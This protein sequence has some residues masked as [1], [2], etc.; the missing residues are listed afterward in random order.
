MHKNESAEPMTLKDKLEVVRGLLQNDNTGLWDVLTCQRGPDTP[1]ERSE[2]TASE[3]SA[4]YKARRER[5]Y[6]TVEVIRAAAGISASGARKH[7]DDKVVLPNSQKWDH[8]DRHVYAAARALGL[9]VE[10]E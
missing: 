5:K 7:K 8:F 9:K 10:Y 1:S 2:M 6:K 3:Y 4:A